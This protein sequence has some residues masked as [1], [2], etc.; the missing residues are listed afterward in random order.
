MRER[1]RER[2][3]ELHNQEI[4]SY[5]SKEGLMDGLLARMGKKRAA[6]HFGWKA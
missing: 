6:E 3:T 4:W 5:R 1:E 2:W